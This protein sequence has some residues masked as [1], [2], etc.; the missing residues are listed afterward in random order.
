MY[1]PTN[2]VR[3]DI[4]PEIVLQTVG[5]FRCLRLNRMRKRTKS[6]GLRKRKRKRKS[7]IGTALRLL[8]VNQTG[9]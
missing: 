3:S 6:N 4:K 8:R 1:R 5:F 2:P 7:K 9:D